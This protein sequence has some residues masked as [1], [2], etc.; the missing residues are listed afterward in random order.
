MNIVKNGNLVKVD[1]IGMLGNQVFNTSMK[2]YAKKAGIHDRKKDYSPLC[3]KVGDANV[4][5]GFNEAVKGMKIG[6]EKTVP[7]P[8]N[9]A[10]GNRK[11]KLVKRYPKAIF[12]N[13]AEELQPGLN[14][15]L[16][17]RS[18]VLKANVVK[19]TRNHVTL[20]MNHELAG[21]TLIFKII[22]REIVK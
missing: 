17:L 2:K 13:Q 21:K 3:F 10:Y 15:K 22:L 5:K 4:I 9:K 16:N 19:N 6:E 1:Y 11:K 7:I 14:V 12:E 20:D 18:G 8:P